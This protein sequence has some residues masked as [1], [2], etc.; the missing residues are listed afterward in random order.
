MTPKQTSEL[1]AS[2]IHQLELV[3][4]IVVDLED[5]NLVIKVRRGKA[6]I[7]VQLI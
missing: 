5:K 7:S 2:V 4:E 6:I 1:L 3:L